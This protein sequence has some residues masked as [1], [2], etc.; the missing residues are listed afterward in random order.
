MAAVV[1]HA[2]RRFPT[3]PPD[4]SYSSY[5]FRGESSRVDGESALSRSMRYADPW[6]YG[7]I[8]APGGFFLTPAFVLCA[9]PDYING[10]KKSSKKSP[11]QCKKCKGAR[12]PLSS[13]EASKYGTV[14]YYP[15]EAV[16]ASSTPVRGGTVRVTSSK[17]PS[18]L[19]SPGDP[20]DLV[21]KSRLS[22]TE[23]TNPF[24][25]RSV[26]PSKTTDGDNKKK[27]G[28]SKAEKRIES[29]N[30]TIGRRSILECDINPYEL[31]SS[32]TFGPKEKESPAVTLVNG[33]RIRIRPSV[34]DSEYE[35]VQLRLSTPTTKPAAKTKLSLKNIVK[36]SSPILRDKKI[37]NGGDTPK[38]RSK[39][40]SITLINKDRELQQKFK[41]ILKKS[42]ERSPS[43]IERS[44]SLFYI[45]L[46]NSKKKVQFLVNNDSSCDENSEEMIE[47]SYESDDDN[48]FEEAKPVAAEVKLVTP[49]EPTETSLNVS[50]PKKPVS[51]YRS[52]SDRMK[53]VES[54]NLFHDTMAIRHLKQRVGLKIDFS[55]LERLDGI[56]QK[57]K[58]LCLKSS[59][60]SKANINTPSDSGNSSL[61]RNEDL[62][63]TNLNNLIL[64]EPI[65]V[66]ST[67]DTETDNAETDNT[68]ASSLTSFSSDLTDNANKIMEIPLKT[69]EPSE[70][71]DE[72]IAL[73]KLD[74]CINEA[75]VEVVVPKDDVPPIVPP[76]KRSSNKQ[77]P[78]SNSIKIEA[79]NTEVT[80]KTVVKITTPPAV[81]KI[82]IKNE[83]SEAL[84][85]SSFNILENAQRKTSIMIN[86][87]D[88]YSTVNVNDN[89]PLYQS[90]VV[91]K[92]S[93]GI[94]PIFEK[95]EKQ[96]STIYITGSFVPC[97]KEPEK[98][99]EKADT[100]ET[101]VEKPAEKD[102]DVLRELLKDP[103]EAVRRN[104]VPH[105]C[106][107]S[108][109][110][111]RQRDKKFLNVKIPNLTSN[112]LPETTYEDVFMRPKPYESICDDLSSEHS[113]STQYELIDPGSDCYTDHSN[114]SSVTEEELANRTKFYELLADSGIIEVT[115]N[116]DHIYESI[117]VNNDPIYED[118]EIPPP[119]P[120]APPPANIMDDINLDKEFTTR[121]IFEGASKYDILSY[122]VD[123]K[124]RGLVQ[125]DGYTYFPT[126]GTTEDDIPISQMSAVSDSSED[127]SLILAGTLMDEKLT[128]Q[129]G[130]EV[131][132]NDSGVGSE[133]SKSS[134]SKY[135]SKQEIFALCEDCEAS[136]EGANG[137]VALLCRKC[138][139]KR[140]ERKEIIT[141][142][143]ETEEKY[144]KDLQIILEEFYQPM[145]VAGL[146][147][148]DQLSAIFLNVEELLENSQA[149]AERLRDGVE[150][151]VEQGD[152]DLLT[153]NMGKLFLEAMP[154]LHAF[155]T[156]CVRQGAASLLLASLE[157]EKELLRIFLRVS[158]MENT[159]LR[160]MN[161]NSFLM[162][163]VQRVTK[164]PLLL[165]RLYKVTPSHYDN[166]EELKEAQHKIELH[167][168]HMNSQT[169]DVPSKLW[170]RIGSS[171]GR[172]SSSEM[173]LVNIK[174]RKIAVDVLEWN[175][176]EAKFALEGKLLFTQPTDNNWRKGRTIKLTPINAMLVINGKPSPNKS[177]DR[178]EENGGLFFSK[179]GVREAALLLVRDKNG[180]YSLLRDPLYLDRCVIAADPAW[181][182]YFEVQEL[183]GKDTFI[184]KAEDEE[185]TSMWYKQLQHHAQGMGAWRKRRNALANI[186]ING[187]GLRS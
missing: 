177:S 121:S 47:N 152:E 117:K 75:K 112:L 95:P 130:A 34:S 10:T 81:H 42:S 40:D 27:H 25:A 156:Y 137:N 14:R 86:G 92:D 148:P 140:S 150:I 13:V 94:I 179:T 120:S 125:E 55:D 116:D 173:D 181:Q 49:K 71:L 48:V 127:N 36:S 28:K 9:C 31:V 7:S 109:V 73:A 79:V 105:V 101:E 174:L 138:V 61:E 133:T 20:Y 141:E 122:L 82:Q 91:V 97:E 144:S 129:K 41:S 59:S 161:L 6:L 145:L 32:E 67:T 29:Y 160:R 103:V 134:L 115:E 169:K 38:Q 171:S 149:L 123:A 106:G 132:R 118:I 68:S 57:I 142:I 151:A 74:M 98:V 8:R 83:C 22:V 163:P 37:L 102:S 158:Q 90:S 19:P 64:Q 183:L 16:A 139:K 162:V 78:L 104:L 155:E 88:C 46:P 128:T 187:M 30:L 5:A 100:K 186:M 87:D 185:Q 15:S 153:V 124:E 45:P 51:L 50:T 69:E 70:K 147:T 44:G 146:L 76:R 2:M 33:Q 66:N 99:E 136:L 164:Y 12:L 111:R 4:T 110:P 107:K 60:A 96:C 157:K 108:D 21:R 52:L 172:R 63:L 165:A 175:H 39:S 53:K 89:I 114:R 143:V 168:N 3:T 178:S 65:E 84:N 17:R 170:R 58:K 72:K 119:L 24:R 93:V 56:N 166:K 1:S 135:R 180:R 54:K 62:S 77:P 184:F 11:S 85:N 35:D 126:N 80:N 18:I 154:M 167:L 159:M 131:E 176:E 113:S 182:S 26:S 43:P 23:N